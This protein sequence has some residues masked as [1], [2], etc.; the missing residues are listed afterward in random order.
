MKDYLENLLAGIILGG[1]CLFAVILLVI[2][3]N[4]IQTNWI[5]V[6]GSVSDYSVYVTDTGIDWNVNWDATFYIP[7]EYRYVK[8]WGQTMVGVACIT[9]HWW[10]FDTDCIRDNSPMFKR[11]ETV[12]IKYNP[13]VPTDIVAERP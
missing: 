12:L 2:R 8:A 13:K 1:I 6:E 11:G 3:Q 9:I 5:Q 10:I 4:D 7:S